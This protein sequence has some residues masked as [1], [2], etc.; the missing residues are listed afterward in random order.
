MKFASFLLFP[1]LRVFSFDFFFVSLNK[2]LAIPRDVLKYL[3]NT[4]PGLSD[5]L[6]Y[7]LIYQSTL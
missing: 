6:G 1:E 7:P 2:G 4:F 5:T 3:G